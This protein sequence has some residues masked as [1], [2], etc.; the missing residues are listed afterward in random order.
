MYRCTVYETN[1]LFDYITIFSIVCRDINFL[2]G[3]LSDCKDITTLPLNEV[4]QL[5]KP[6]FKFGCG[7]Q[8]VYCREWRVG[9]AEWNRSDQSPLLAYASS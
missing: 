1:A 7:S 3:P 2:T 9:R 8:H 5:L 4:P 6:A